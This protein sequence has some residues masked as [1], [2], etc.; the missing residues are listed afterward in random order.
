MSFADASRDQGEKDKTH[1]PSTAMNS[2]VALWPA[3][4][5]I[6]DPIVS[7]VCMAL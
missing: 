2:P 7:P 1:N 6:P 3:D 5:G 4:F